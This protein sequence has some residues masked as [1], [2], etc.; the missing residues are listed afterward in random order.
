MSDFSPAAWLSSAQLLAAAMLAFRLGIDGTLSRKLSAW[1]ALALWVL[2]LDEQFMLH[3]HW[4]YGCERW[5]AVCTYAWVR[6][7]PT[8]LACVR[9]GPVTQNT[10]HAA[11]SDKI[12]GVIKLRRYNPLAFLILKSP[13]AIDCG[14]LEVSRLR[15]WRL[16]RLRRAVAQHRL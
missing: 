4:K 15:N 5:I 10:R 3:E 6:E 11:S 16:R 13:T 7:L 8:L 2:A 12:L 9:R 1:L 14:S